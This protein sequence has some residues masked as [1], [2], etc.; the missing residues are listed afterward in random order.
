MGLT[1]DF[2]LPSFPMAFAMS[3]TRRV[4]PLSM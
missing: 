1:S 4:E 2:E 3:S